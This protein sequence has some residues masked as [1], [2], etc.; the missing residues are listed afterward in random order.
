MPNWCMNKLYIEHSDENKIVEFC[1]AFEKDNVCEHYIPTPRDENGE[2][3]EDWWGYRVA[4]WGT[5]WDIGVGSGSISRNKNAVYCTFDSAWSPPIGL[6]EHL[7]SLGFE[8]RASYFEPG[9]MFGGHW[10]DGNDD[11]YE[12][13]VQDFPDSL[14]EAY[15][16]LDW[17]EQEEPA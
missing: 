3:L 2:L 4:N 17:F 9:M 13:E 6:Y 11:Y 5:K 12:G 14:I 8:I 1:E 16:I 10:Y 7:Y 15:D